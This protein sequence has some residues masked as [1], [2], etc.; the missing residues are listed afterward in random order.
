MRKDKGVSQVTSAILLLIVTLS[1]LAY[2]VMEAN[3]LNRASITV[4]SEVYKK[5]SEKIS[6]GL[7]LVDIYINGSS[8][9][10]LVY[11]YGEEEVHVLNILH[12]LKNYE[13][14]IY[15]NGRFY[16]TNIIP[17]KTLVLIVFHNATLEDF[18]PIVLEVKDYGVYEISE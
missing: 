15:D 6:T 8:A 13:I 2:Y 11:N 17:P 5:L 18:S 10:A 1:S 14:Y 16:K 4:L 3:G 9:I 12:P 7:Q